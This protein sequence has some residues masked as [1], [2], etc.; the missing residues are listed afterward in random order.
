M[1]HRSDYPRSDTPHPDASGG[2]DR[3]DT[4]GAE[5][6]LVEL[7]RIVNRNRQ[8]AAHGRVEATDY[9]AGLEQEELLK[10]PQGD[11]LAPPPLAQ[12]AQP[13]TGYAPAGRGADMPAYTPGLGGSPNEPAFDFDFEVPKPAARAAAAPGAQ[14]A[15]QADPAPA[16]G[17][18]LDLDFDRFA[19]DLRG[20]QEEETAWDGVDLEDG[21]TLD[22]D[23]FEDFA[24]EPARESYSVAPAADQYQP[25][26]Q[27]LHRTGSRSADPA[28]R[29][30]DEA[31]TAPLRS[32]L[33]ISDDL[34]KDLVA[35]LED[36]LMGAFQ[37]QPVA[38]D[39]RIEPQFSGN[40]PF[41]V[42]AS[43]SQ[44]AAAAPVRSPSLRSA[45][46]DDDVRFDA[47]R[48]VEPEK[49]KAVTPPPFVPD[50]G[51]WSNLAPDAKL[52]SAR[53]ASAGF[54]EL[55]DLVGSL[56]EDERLSRKEQPAQ[57]KPVQPSAD[58]D[59]MAWPD[60]LHVLPREEG[61]VEDDFLDDEFANAFAPR[62]S[63]TEL[64]FN[65]VL[66]DDD[67]APP[68]PGGYDLDAVARAMQESDPTLAGA[69]VLPPHS[70][71]E[72]GQAPRQQ[73]SRKGLYI[74]AAV[75]GLA[76]LGG[77]MFAVLDF[78]PSSKPNGAPQVIAGLEEPLKTFPAEEAAAAE[79]GQPAKLIYDRVGNEER[80]VVPQTPAP[81]QL[82]PAPAD[83]AEPAP[84]GGPKK[85]RTLVVRPDGTII[86]GEA[87]TG[88][89]AQPGVRV[90]NTARPDASAQPAQ[91]APA[92]ATG[93]APVPG[94]I[95]PAQSNVAA[96]V[97]AIVSAT[98]PAATP[99]PATTETGP[100][101][102][103][104]PRP[105]P[106]SSGVQVAAV[107]PQPAA[108]APAQPQ[109]PAPA[110]AAQSSGPLNLTQPQP[111]A[112]ASPAPAAASPAA[113]GAFSVQVTSQ[114]TQ[115][116]AQ[117]AYTALQ[118]KFPSVLGSQAPLIEAA[119]LDSR[120]TFYRVSIPANSREAAVS[121]CENLKAAGG[122]CFVRRN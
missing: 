3:G 19:A 86:S 74:A 81:A 68:P 21:T 96:N 12:P 82:P 121:F 83:V 89:A 7:A 77:A 112:A 109:Q 80:M 102:S 94:G 118:R 79:S 9:F 113:P 45:S 100:V 48:A 11:P 14:T 90:V 67:E 52:R 35:G 111:A 16:R 116:Q 73:G 8:S 60:A 53:E 17:G 55:D 27:P 33:D 47:L 69:G 105:K 78:G 49:P 25:Q 114:R 70:A 119:T 10:G 106:A 39:A 71:A 110:P 93:P 99:A 58:I 66:Y 87:D 28:P 61:P 107:Q 85:V 91:P 6:P 46:V 42:Q 62:R 63:T 20:P 59:D 101:V 122:D 98:D 120:G 18:D 95:T 2:R 24:D 97:P 32:S 104:T 29:S 92:A 103:G 26:H 54:A 22:A 65:D 13:S 44:P 75:L 72:A 23:S 36:E 115:D 31:G 50:A 5:D 76:G 57:T 1:P 108:P 40:A 88:A 38:R 84:A 34:E 37:P 30:Y 43:Q 64:P 4:Q 41:E 15:V 117:A 56:F 51:A